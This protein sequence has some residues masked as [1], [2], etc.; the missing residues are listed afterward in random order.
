VGWY[1]YH[2][3][4][5]RWEWSAE[6]QAMHGYQSD[7]ADPSTALVFEHAHPEDREQVEHALRGVRETAAP[8]SIRHRIINVHN[9]VRK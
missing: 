2:F 7:P 3:A 4:D 6:V 5:E 9:D 1:R 8:F